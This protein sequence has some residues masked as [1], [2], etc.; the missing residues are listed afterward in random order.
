MTDYICNF[1][2]SVSFDEVTLCKA[3]S[4]LDDIHQ[5]FFPLTFWRD[6]REK[7]T[8]ERAAD[9]S[10]QAI[11]S[12]YFIEPGVA[13]IPFDAANGAAIV[14][15][16]SEMPILSPPGLDIEFNEATIN[17]NAW[18]V[19]TFFALFKAIAMSFEPK[20]G[21]LA[22]IEEL[23]RPDHD[24]VRFSIDINRVPISLH[25][26][27]YFGAEWVQRIGV[28]R[29]DRLQGEVAAFERLDT[30]AILFALQEEPFREANPM[31]VATQQKFEAVLDLK[32]L[33]RAHPNVGF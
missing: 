33:H 19:P 26:I 31:H 22:D 21:H 23:T 12:E 30:G 6:S 25:W 15:T 2:R 27:N 8:V 11:P 4:A 20:H 24:G 13:R 5:G 14:F 28:E 16:E 9:F 32:S 18:S 7:L 29:L 10:R 17:A 3:L 1:Y